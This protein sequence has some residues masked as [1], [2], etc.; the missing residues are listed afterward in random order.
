MGTRYGWS[1][2]LSSSNQV[3]YP[4]FPAFWSY[5]DPP[6]SSEVFKA[7]YEAG[8][9][10][11]NVSCVQRNSFGEIVLTFRKNEFK[12]QF[13]RQNVLNLGGAP[14]VLQD[15]D[16]PLTYLPIFDAPHELPDTTII[17][18]L[19][20]YCDVIH[21]RR[22]KFREKEWEHG[23]DGVRHYQ[24]RIKSPIPDS[25]RFARIQIHLCYDG[26]PCKC[27]HCNQTGHMANACDTQVCFNCDQIDLASLCP[28]A[29]LW[30][31]CKSENHKAKDCPLSWSREVI[32]D[33][34]DED[35]TERE[36]N[37]SHDG[38]EDAI[39]TNENSAGSADSA[40]LNT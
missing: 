9:E 7:L 1:A 29:V 18:R 11:T 24:V 10:A 12:E 33:N 26:Q 2:T 22:S 21:H 37:T 15:V 25:P 32:S 34:E 5:T 36:N 40:K 38:G 28:V 13:L 31:I 30:N 39:T 14:L 27:C 35:N 19:A 4:K 8:I 23:M 20:K 3:P 17:N 16:K 6:S